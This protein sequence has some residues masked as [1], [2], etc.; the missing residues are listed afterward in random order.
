MCVR[1]LEDL[2]ARVD[3]VTLDPSPQRFG[4]K[5][6]RDWIALME[7]VRSLAKLRV[8][9]ATGGDA[10]AE[11]KGCGELTTP[12]GHVRGRDGRRADV[13]PP[14]ASLQEE[15]P[16]QKSLLSPA[17]LPIFPELSQQF[18]TSF[19]SGPRIDYGTGHE[20]AFLA[21][22][23]ILRLVGVFSEQDE[24]AIVTRIFVA[25]LVLVRKL[26][27]VFK[28]E[29]A[30]SKGVWGLDDHQHLVYLWGASQLRTHPTLRPATILSPSSI[31][32]QGIS[33]LFLSSILHV[34][35]LK[36]GPFAEHSPMLH[37]I[38]TTVPNWAKVNTGLTKMYRA[39][40]LEKVPVV[41]HFRFG[42]I[43]AWRRKDS[44][45]VM[46]ASSPSLPLPPCQL[47]H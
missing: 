21:Y 11:T 34:N 16:F 7:K 47:D 3:D 2:T 32:P 5:A 44:G 18:R 27:K 26:Q 42:G 22:L 24:Q 41:Q 20:L 38:A 8:G 13:P 17:Q 40:V 31:S 9:G 45:E 30:G 25:Y 4:N 15:A 14:L 19:G 6:F 39:E 10:P 35:D 37:N 23:L 33:Y 12:S 1:F 46:C 43:L 29:P 36:S 28:L